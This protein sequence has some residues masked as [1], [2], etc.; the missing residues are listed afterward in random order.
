MECHAC[1]G[2]NDPA[3]F[4]R[5]RVCTSAIGLQSERQKHPPCT[6]HWRGGCCVIFQRYRMPCTHYLYYLYAQGFSLMSVLPHLINGTN[7]SHCP[8]YGVRGVS[9]V[10][11][12][13][14]R[15]L[16]PKHKSGTRESAV[17]SFFKQKIETHSRLA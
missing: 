6:R 1:L 4:K 2:S 9:Y 11:P 14:V 17:R 7:R 12:S 16:K 10:R 5:S 13:S 15:L 8:E 3:T